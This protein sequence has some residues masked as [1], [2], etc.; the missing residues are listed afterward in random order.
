MYCL[1]GGEP[2][3]S[4]SLIPNPAYMYLLLIKYKKSKTNEVGP[5]IF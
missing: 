1:Q 5:N 2:Y 4:D 3:F